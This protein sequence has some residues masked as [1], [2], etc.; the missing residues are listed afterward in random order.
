MSLE[1]LQMP[2]NKHDRLRF[3]FAFSRLAII[4][5]ASALDATL[6]GNAFPV[7][8]KVDSEKPGLSVM[9]PGHYP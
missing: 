8:P 2:Q 1:L 7:S 6:L 3:F 5:F 9:S 4:A